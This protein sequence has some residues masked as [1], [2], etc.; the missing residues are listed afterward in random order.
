MNLSEKD[1][2]AVEISKDFYYEGKSQAKIAKERSMH[3]SSVSR[4]LKYALDVGIVKI[5]IN[6]KNGPTFTRQKYPEDEL[7]KNFLLKNAI[8]IELPKATESGAVGTVGAKKLDDELHKYLGKATASHLKT[9][10]RSDDHMATG[11][12]RATYNTAIE[13]FDLGSPP[14]P[15]LNQENITVTSLNGNSDTRIRARNSPDRYAHMPLDSDVVVIDMAPAFKSGAT[16]NRMCL[17][18][19]GDPEKIKGFK[20]KQARLLSKDYWEQNPQKVPNIVLFGIGAFLGAHRFIEEPKGPILS[21]IKSHLS[22]LK[23]DSDEL[24]KICGYIPVGDVCNRLF[25]IPPPNGEENLNPRTHELVNKIKGEIKDINDH[26][27]TID[28][29]QLEMVNTVIAVAGGKNKRDAIY[30]VLTDFEPKGVVDVLVT[31][32]DTAEYLINRRLMGNSFRPN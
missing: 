22:S 20:K 19:V 13:L 17:P 15:S 31:D 26:L 2:L 5:E 1:K 28:F 14:N 32:K 7:V 23:K 18:L 6:H 16:P 25:F 11:G 3:P 21:H 9:I 4:I 29:K 10:L 27:L 24:G 8:V 12:G 30:H